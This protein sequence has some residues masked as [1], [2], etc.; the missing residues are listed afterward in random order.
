MRI[1]I[2]TLCVWALQR[3]RWGEEREAAVLRMRG[4]ECGGSAVLVDE[5][6]DLM[7][8]KRVRTRM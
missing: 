4:A 5:V 1:G 7:H 2:P 3:R 6:V 8:M